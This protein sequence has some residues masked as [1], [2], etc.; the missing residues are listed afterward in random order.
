VSAHGR[1]RR[2]RLRE[3]AKDYV[4]TGKVTLE[5]QAVAYYSGKALHG[6]DGPRLARAGLAVWDHDPDSFWTF[7]ECIIIN[8]ETDD[9]WATPKQLERIATVSGV[10][11]PQTVYDAVIGDVYE[12]ELQET[13]DAGEKLSVDDMPRLTVDGETYSPNDAEKLHAAIDDAVAANDE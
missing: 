7:V 1:V 11:D 9:G 12:T 4:L 10:D 3:F 8:L 2:R 5:L 13:M 6:E